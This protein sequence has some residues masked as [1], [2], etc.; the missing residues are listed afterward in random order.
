MDKLS[1]RKKGR[2]KQRKNKTKIRIKRR[3][4]KTSRKI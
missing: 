4:N 2:T 3:T 1:K